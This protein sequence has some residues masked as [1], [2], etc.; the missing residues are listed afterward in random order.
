MAGFTLA[1]TSTNGIVAELGT[2]LGRGTLFSLMMVVT[3]LPALL[4]TFDTVIRKNHTGR[5][6]PQDENEEPEEPQPCATNGAAA[7]TPPPRP[8]NRNSPFPQTLFSPA[9][10][11]R[12]PAT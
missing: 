2:L 7:S 10:A 5:R 3:V 6:L 11:C 8:T 1:M 9:R 4:T 12:R